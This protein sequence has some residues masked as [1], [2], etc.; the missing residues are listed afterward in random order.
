MTDPVDLDYAAILGTTAACVRAA[1]AAC[2]RWRR[3][4]KRGVHDEPERRA[5]LEAARIRLFAAMSDLSS[6]RH[7]MGTAPGRWAFYQRQA[8]AQ[9]ARNARRSYRRLYRMLGG[10][11]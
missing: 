3:P 11:R 1:E 6:L 9:A 5:E 7:S 8:A 10:A 2:A 4:G